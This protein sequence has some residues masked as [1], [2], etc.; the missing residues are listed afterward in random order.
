MQNDK[1]SQLCER[2]HF[3]FS[4]EKKSQKWV[5]KFARGLNQTFDWLLANVLAVTMILLVRYRTCSDG[6][7]FN[8]NGIK[9]S[10]VIFDINLSIYISCN[11]GLWNV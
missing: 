1:I 7:Q 9:I 3:A 10:L 5:V 6:K 8:L 4:L 2:T 11:V